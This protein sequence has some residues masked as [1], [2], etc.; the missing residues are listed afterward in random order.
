MLV[1]YE[2]TEQGRLE[3]CRMVRSSGSTELDQAVCHAFTENGRFLPAR[4]A[5]GEPR[6]TSGQTLLRVQID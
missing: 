3:N 6:R 5:S 2:I 1:T 4:T